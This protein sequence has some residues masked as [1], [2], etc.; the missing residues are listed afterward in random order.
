MH[1]RNT[2]CMY[3]PVTG[4]WQSVWLEAVASS[5]L[6]RPR[7][8][9]QL[10]AGAFLIEHRIHSPVPGLRVRTS[11]RAGGALL[12]QAQTACDLDGVVCQQIN[13]PVTAIRPWCPADPFLYDLEYLLIDATGQPLDR[14]DG[15]AGLRSVS[16][17]GDLFLLNG[18]PIFQ[19]L[20][21]DQGWWPEGMLTAPSDAELQA[22]I[23]RAMAAGFNGARLHQKIF[24]ERFLYHAD[25]LGYLVWGEFPDWCS[26]G[27][28]AERERDD[29]YPL[30]YVHEWIEVVER[31]YS[32]PAIIGW[33]P[34]NE[35]HAQRADFRQRL[36]AIQRSLID[37]TRAA[38]RSRPVI[39]ASG[40]LHQLPDAD[41][42][43]VH[44]YDQDP[45]SF[46]ARYADLPAQRG[47]PLGLGHPPNPGWQLPWTG[48]PFFVSEFGGIK[49]TQTGSEG[50]GY[51][52]SATDKEA[53]YQRFTALIEA[54]LFNPA[55]C[56]YC[57]TQLTDVCQE[58]NGIYTFDRQ[59]RFD[60][61]RL[62]AIQA[63]PAAY[64]SRQIA[65]KT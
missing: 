18:R 16:I 8:T 40:W 36:W 9:P 41:V 63:R 21:L 38:D 29:R 62:R 64:E 10:A 6:K 52:A 19:R 51:G 56:G 35:I 39:D 15:Y 46:A 59:E 54:L 1:D 3:T 24:E 55:V 30:A 28:G 22:D 17:Q 4:I 31:D 50:W 37:A 57:Y 48:Q 44:D 20:V 12:A 60:A 23:R 7:I 11:L 13:I 65:A 47:K 32:H 33:C 27:M 61:T 25:R 26:A 58:V 14:A 45:A 42:Y 5:S 2:G 43:D 34:L 49:L 53:F